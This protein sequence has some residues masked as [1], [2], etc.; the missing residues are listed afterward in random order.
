MK[1]LAMM[2]MAALFAMSVNASAWWIFGQKAAEEPAKEET[3]AATE[4]QKADKAP[5]C[6]KME[7]KAEKKA[8]KKY[9]CEG[10]KAK[11]ASMSEEDKAKCIADCK[12]KKAE[13]KAE[14][15]AKWEAKKAQK[16]A[17]KAEKAAEAAAEAAPAAE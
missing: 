8:G 2:V 4:V 1:K 12:A 5:C 6:Q 17:Q 9:K 7:Q 11:C 13:K 14:K 3:P 15:K 10:K 16:A